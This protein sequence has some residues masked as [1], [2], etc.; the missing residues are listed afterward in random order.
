MKIVV[1]F[2]G[3]LLIP[4]DDNL[5]MGGQREAIVRM[6]GRVA[7]MIAAGH[8]L[9]ITHGNAPQIGNM[10]FRAA[11]ASHIVHPLPLDICGADT[12][13]ATGYM[14]QQVLHN[15]LQRH[16]LEKEITTIV[17]QVLVEE[18]P[19]R[20]PT[21]KGIGPYLDDN[22]ARAFTDYRGWEFARHPERGYQRIVRALKPTRIVEANPI[23]YLVD[24]GVTV[25]CAGGGGVP[26]HLGD[27]QE[28][29]GLEAVVDKAYTA[30]LLAREIQA[31]LIIFVSHQTD[32][33]QTF[34]VDPTSGLHPFKL[35]ALNELLGSREELIDTMRHKLIAGQNYLLHGGKTVLLVPPDH[36][37]PDPES[38][39]GIR[40]TSN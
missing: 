40:L 20:P 19:A 5:G 22:K 12:Q 37:A 28:M 36:L 31:D 4:R 9:V 10:L 30:T 6:M 1:V 15:W 29:T 24:R 34:K 21:T 25:I 2:D 11:A 8:E 26:V 3:D 14:M 23:R 16:G 32:L 27:G 33:A 35:M 18:D 39:H 38:S 7:E 13:G 17:T